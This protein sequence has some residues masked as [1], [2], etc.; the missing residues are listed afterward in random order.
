LPD[1]RIADPLPADFA[2]LLPVLFAD[3]VSELDDVPV[4]EPLLELLPALDELEE[5]ALGAGGFAVGRTIG[6]GRMESSA[7]CGFSPR[8]DAL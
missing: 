8:P 1:E 3:P 2:V 6:V 4:A 5:P 7:T